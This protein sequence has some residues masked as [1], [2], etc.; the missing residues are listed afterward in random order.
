V[1]RFESYRGRHS[2]TN[3]PP[4]R[5]VRVRSTPWRT[6]PSRQRCPERRVRP[7]APPATAR[8]A[9]GLEIPDVGERVLR[10]LD[11][12]TPSV[13]VAVEQRARLRLEDARRVLG[14]EDS[15]LSMRSLEDHRRL[16]KQLLAPHRK[17]DLLAIPQDQA[18]SLDLAIKLRHTLAHRSE[19]AASEL[20]IALTSPDLADPLRRVTQ[21]GGRV[22]AGRVGRYLATASH[23]WL[24]QCWLLDV[25]AD[26]AYA[27]ARGP[28]RHRTICDC[29][30]R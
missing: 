30:A 13:T 24:R 20:N 25:L 3:K 8:Y 10:S 1:R 4:M 11:V 17:R 18:A 26:I 5:A 14:V 16:A 7:R 15:A 27:I 29:A 21:A 9:A 2:H 22:T 28:G 12:L 19:R 23:G 6:R